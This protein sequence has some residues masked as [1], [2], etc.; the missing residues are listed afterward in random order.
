MGSLFLD[1]LFLLS[2]SF[3]GAQKVFLLPSFLVRQRQSVQNAT[4]QQ[5]TRFSKNVDLSKCASLL[6]QCSRSFNKPG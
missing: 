6:R 5:M 2:N 4:A 1:D 3:Q